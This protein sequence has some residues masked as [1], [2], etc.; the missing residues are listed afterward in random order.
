[1]INWYS[2]Q[3]VIGMINL[4]NLMFGEVAKFDMFV[5]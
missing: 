3:L 2:I 5:N 4:I 1:M